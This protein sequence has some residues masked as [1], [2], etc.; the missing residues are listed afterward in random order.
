[1]AQMRLASAE[2]QL[3]ARLLM[4]GAAAARNNTSGGHASAAALT[5]GLSNG[6]APAHAAAAG[7]SRWVGALACWAVGVYSGWCSELYIC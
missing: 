1:M 6:P 2:P 3:T 4:A 7:S 5:D